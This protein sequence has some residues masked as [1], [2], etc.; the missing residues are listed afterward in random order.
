MGDRL[1][2]KVAIVTGAGTVLAG[3][4]N[5]KATAI[6]FAR[7]GA[8]V[9]AVDY[10]LEAAEETKRV[11]DEEGGE[12]ITFKAD[13]SR[14]DECRSMIETCVKTFGRVDIVHN[15]VGIGQWGGPVETTEETWDKVMTVNVK[16][17]F[18]TCK[19]VIPYM[20][21]QGSGT[22]INIA[23]VG[24]IRSTLPNIAYA[25]SKAAV[26]G[27]T[28]DVAIQYAEKGIRVNVILPGLMKTPQAEYYNKDAWA[29]G[30]I[31]EMWRRRDS[32]VPMK[33]QGQGW[34]T[35]GA[36][37]FLASDDSQYITGQTIIVDGG[38]S[39]TMRSW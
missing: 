8:R 24:A 23:S 27:L 25:A 30:D 17:M 19:Y 33:R 16:S 11:I 31:D 26:V 35:A 20:E 2:G 34:D 3:L 4:G 9:M 29:G 5:G 13:V 36:A 39:N 37:L 38:I 10:N 22:I 15:N 18:L 6:I 12:C 32:M 7:E 14:A 28:R 21:K 1:K